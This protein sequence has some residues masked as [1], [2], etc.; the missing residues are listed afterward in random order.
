[1]ADGLLENETRPY[2]YGPSLN[3]TE[4]GNNVHEH[5]PKTIDKYSRELAF[6]AE[7]LGDKSVVEL[8]RMG[9]ALYISTQNDD[10]KPEE[11]AA[12]INRLKPHVQLED[13]VAAVREV[14]NMK[15]VFS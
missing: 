4:P 6:I 7:Y 15:K 3:P 8:E 13:A 11:K 2:P 9:T 1:M 12:E 10:K 14:E 5:F